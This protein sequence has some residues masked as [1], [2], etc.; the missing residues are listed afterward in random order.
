MTVTTLTGLV[1]RMV[2]T[3]FTE[4]NKS[5]NTL[6]TETKPEEDGGWMKLEVINGLQATGAR[7][8]R[9]QV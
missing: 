6:Q 5:N 4:Y 8:T 9:T 2:L 1:N 3:I 7:R